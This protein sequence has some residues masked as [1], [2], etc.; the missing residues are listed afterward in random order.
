MN[1]ALHGS[2]MSTGEILEAKQQLGESDFDKLYGKMLNSLLEDSARFDELS[3]TEHEDF[4]DEQYFHYCKCFPD[5]CTCSSDSPKPSST[6][7][8]SNSEDFAT[9]SLNV[10]FNF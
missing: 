4:F 7:F 3:Q 10:I 6:K 8:P 1:L 9:R 2:E 5:T